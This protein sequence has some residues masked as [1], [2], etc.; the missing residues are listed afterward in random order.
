MSLPGLTLR[1]ILHVDPEKVEELER[2]CAEHVPGMSNKEPPLFDDEVKFY[3]GKRMVIQVIPCNEDSAWT[4]GV[5]LD[6]EGN[7]LGMTDVGESFL[8]EYLVECG[9]VTYITVV[10]SGTEGQYYFPIEITAFGEDIDTAWREACEGFS[11]D[12]GVPPDTYDFE[13]QEE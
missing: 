2:Y 12:P 7:E 1:K 13:A 11:Q 9:N 6:E 8:G 5:M 4:Q 3:T 10:V